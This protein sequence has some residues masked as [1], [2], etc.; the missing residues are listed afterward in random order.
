[1]AAQVGTPSMSTPVKSISPT[2]GK[3]ASVAT[4]E[5]ITPVVEVVPGV[6]GPEMGTVVDTSATSTPVVEAVSGVGGPEKTEITN[7]GS[8]RVVKDNEKESYVLDSDLEAQVDDEVSEETGSYVVYML[9]QK[10]VLVLLQKF[11]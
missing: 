10:R 4:P 8:N 11:H 2:V 3:G 6:G 1:M 7:A 5:M 9:H